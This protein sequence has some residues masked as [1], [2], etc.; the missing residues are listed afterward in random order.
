MARLLDTTAER[1]AYQHRHRECGP[2]C[3]I[4]GDECPPFVPTWSDET[5]AAAPGTPAADFEAALA[6]AGAELVRIEVELADLAGRTVRPDYG[7][8]G[9]LNNLV[10]ALRDLSPRNWR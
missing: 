10:A 6:E 7:H 3:C 2:D 9:S 4:T 8:V 1:S 5:P